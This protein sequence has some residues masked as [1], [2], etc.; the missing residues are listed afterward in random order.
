MFITSI[1]NLNNLLVDL[2]K[3]GKADMGFHNYRD[4]AN[5]AVEVM[6]THVY[7]EAEFTALKMHALEAMSFAQ[8]DGVTAE[9]VFNCTATDS[10]F[11]ISYYDYDPLFYEETV[12]YICTVKYLY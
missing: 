4:K 1:N 10:S 6:I 2:E 5:K 8:T 9:L 3:A 11:S 12:K 7:G